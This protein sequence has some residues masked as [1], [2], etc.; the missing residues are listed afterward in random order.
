MSLVLIYNTQSLYTFS[1]LINLHA[2]YCE[3]TRTSLDDE[4]CLKVAV[5]YFITTSMLSLVHVRFVSTLGFFF[6]SNKTQISSTTFYFAFLHNGCFWFVVT[7]CWE[8]NHFDLSVSLLRL[9]VIAIASIFHPLSKLLM[10]AKLGV[11]LLFNQVYILWCRFQP[12]QI[13][14][15]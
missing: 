8:V 2:D 10:L 12:F 6:P 14:Q 15:S 13:L 9:I 3:F 1:I 7:L 4:V 11:N 5:I